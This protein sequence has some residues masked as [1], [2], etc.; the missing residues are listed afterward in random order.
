[1]KTEEAVKAFRDIMT[2]YAMDKHGKIRRGDNFFE[3]IDAYYVN[4]KHTEFESYLGRLDTGLPL[5]SKEGKKQGSVFSEIDLRI[6]EL[7]RDL[8]DACPELVAE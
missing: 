2:E 3:N 6:L 5:A 7:F 8:L 4:R 1:M